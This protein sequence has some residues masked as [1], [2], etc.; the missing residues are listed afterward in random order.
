M[1][2][3]RHLIDQSLGGVAVLL[4]PAD[5]GAQ[6]D[7]EKAEELVRHHLKQAKAQLQRFEDAAMGLT[8]WG[9]GP[10]QVPGSKPGG[11]A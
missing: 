9:N 10:G 1:A 6:A 4:A 3:A 11:P 5:D 8:A 7:P 2:V